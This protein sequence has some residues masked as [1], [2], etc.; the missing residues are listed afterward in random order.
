MAWASLDCSEVDLAHLGIGL[1]RTDG[2]AQD[3]VAVPKQLVSS[4]CDT[5]QEQIQGH[6]L[7]L[8]PIPLF[9][10]LKAVESDLVYDERA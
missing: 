8:A 10:E 5:D 3:C 7:Q 6:V 4:S 2:V 1:G 9:P